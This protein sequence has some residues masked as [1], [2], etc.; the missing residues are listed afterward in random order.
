M[1]SGLRKERAGIPPGKGEAHPAELA[2]CHSRTPATTTEL[3]DARDGTRSGPRRL[4]FM[5]LSEGVCLVNVG[6]YRSQ[7]ILLHMHEVPPQRVVKRLPARS[8]YFLVKPT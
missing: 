8:H 5:A 2:R 3:A 6:V 1:C 4:H 7:T